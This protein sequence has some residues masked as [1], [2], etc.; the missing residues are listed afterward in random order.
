MRGAPA[1]QWRSQPAQNISGLPWHEQLYVGHEA[2]MFSLEYAALAPDWARFQTM[3]DSFR[4]IPATQARLSPST[5]SKALPPAHFGVQVASC[6]GTVDNEY[7]PFPC[8]DAGLDGCPIA[9]CG[10]CTW[11]VRYRRTGDNEVN[12]SRCTGD[13]NSWENCAS[14]Y[15]PH[16]LSTEPN[17]EAVTVYPGQN[18]LSFIERMNSPTSYRVSQQSWFDSCPDISFTESRGSGKLYIF[19]PDYIR[20]PNQAPNIPL[21]LYPEAEFLAQFSGNHLGMGR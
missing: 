20:E 8:N 5:L 1:L 12:L 4:F 3:R 6:C 16:L 17:Q 13:A 7:N 10:N 15:Y 2:L 19:H 18:H 21:M 9:P 14:S 11:W